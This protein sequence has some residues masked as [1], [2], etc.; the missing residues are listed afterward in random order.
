MNK[1]LVLVDFINEIVHPEGKLAAK[2]YAEY[3]ERHHTL[4]QVNSLIHSARDK[5]CRILR[6]N[7]QFD[8]N[9]S[10]RPNKSL[11][12][13]SAE[14]FGV[15]KANTWSTE[16][17]SDLAVQSE[18]KEFSKSRISIFSSTEFT[19]FLKDEGI[20]SLILAGVSTDLAVL[21][22]AFNAHD[23]N[24]GI[25][26]AKDACAAANDED[27]NSAVKQLSKFSQVLDVEEI[28]F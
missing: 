16:T 15:L 4:D 17:I 26:I 28:Q 2:G 5:S 6:V 21:A 1:A 11:L 3:I 19:E 24:Y 12:F 10:N 22:S 23:L 18:D 14:K 20:N 25:T 8:V 9:Y 7:I 13:A 27:H